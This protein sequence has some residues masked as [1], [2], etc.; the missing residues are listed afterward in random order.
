MLLSASLNRRANLDS[1]RLCGDRKRERKKEKVKAS[2][3]GFGEL[4]R[5]DVLMTFK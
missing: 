1:E 3:A 5:V 4:R 2:D